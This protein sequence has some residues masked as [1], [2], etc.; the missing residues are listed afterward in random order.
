MGERELRAR[1]P[2]SDFRA[3][4]NSGERGVY[5]DSHIRRHVNAAKITKQ[6]PGLVTKEKKKTLP[7]KEP[8]RN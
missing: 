2:D 4:V 3:L 7:G 8:S 1:I 6:G 5:I